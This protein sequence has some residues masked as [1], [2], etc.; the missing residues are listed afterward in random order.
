ML[1]LGGP[2]EI[3]AAVRV[4]EQLES[5]DEAFLTGTTINVWPVARIDA[6]SLP[7]PLPGPVS[8]RL[9]ARLARVLEGVDPKFSPRWLQK[10]P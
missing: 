5:C 10:L 3:L 6:L 7:E 2:G 9:R 1:I 4:E 8:A